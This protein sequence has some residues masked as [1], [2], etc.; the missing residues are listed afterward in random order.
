MEK[1]INYQSF[2]IF[3]WLLHLFQ[4]ALFAYSINMNLFSSTGFLSI[5]IVI[6]FGL[7]PVSFAGIGARDVLLIFIFGNSYGNVK[8][9]LLGFMMTLRYI[10]PATIGIISMRELTKEN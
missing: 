8:P 7:L 9:L 2:S 3:V 10:L 4:I 5:G 1:F 6:L